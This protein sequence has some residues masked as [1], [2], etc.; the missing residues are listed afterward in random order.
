VETSNDKKPVFIIGVNERLS[1]P[2]GDSTFFY[3]RLTPSKHTELRNEYTD[4]GLFD[5]QARKNF[6]VAIASYCL[7]GWEN[8]LDGQMQQVPFLVDVIPYLP[9]AVL[10]KLDQVAMQ[11]SPEELVARFFALSSDN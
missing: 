5:E 9:W 10:E 4:R 11:E 1:F 3:R 6:L 7:T 2:V 8:V